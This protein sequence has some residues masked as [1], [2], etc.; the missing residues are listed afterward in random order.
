M[1]AV[2]LQARTGAERLHPAGARRRAAGRRPGGRARGIRR[3]G[4]GAG[5]AGAL[6][7]TRPAHRG[8]AGCGRRSSAGRTKARSACPA[9]R[10]PGSA[11]RW[12]AKVGPYW[13][14]STPAQLAGRP[15][16]LGL[17]RENSKAPDQFAIWMQAPEGGQAY[18]L[19][20][21]VRDRTLAP[22]P[23]LA[24]GPPPGAGTR[25]PRGRAHGG[26]PGRHALP[27]AR[28]R[29]RRH[30]GSRPPRDGADRAGVAG[31]CAKGRA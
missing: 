1:F 18:A 7:L 2:R 12:P 14:L 11:Q 31:P 3:A 10:A 8:A 17:R 21:V 27:P 23:Y 24:A 20:L 19:R 22:D 30:G 6:R 13:T 15:A 28:R 26:A 16:T 25:L 5:A 9:A 29:R 4:A